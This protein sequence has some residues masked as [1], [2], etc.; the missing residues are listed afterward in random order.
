MI[1]TAQADNQGAFSSGKKEKAATTI[2]APKTQNIT[3]TQ[4]EDSDKGK[5]EDEFKKLSE[6]MREYLFTEITNVAVDYNYSIIDNLTIDKINILQSTLLAMKKS[7]E[8]LKVDYDIVL[9]DGNRAFTNP[10]SISTSCKKIETVIKGDAKSLSIAAASIIAK[11][12]RD[13]EMLKLHYQYPNYGWDRNKGYPTK[14]H[15]NAIKLYGI[16]PVHRMKFLTR[17]VPSSIES[18]QEELNLFE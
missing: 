1:I 7:L 15:I 2:V 17:I 8:K 3:A 18:R 4:P 11:V 14:E 16:T 9:I 12:V 6:E 13:R 5:F 10:D